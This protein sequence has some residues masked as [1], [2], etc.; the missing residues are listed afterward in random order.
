MKTNFFRTISIINKNKYINSYVGV[1]RHI[2]WVLRKLF[3]IFPCDL[4]LGDQLIRI[5]NR[6]IANGNGALINAMGYYDPNNMLLLKELF[7]KEVYISFFDI[8]ANIGVYSLIVAGQMKLGSVN[9][10]AFEPHPQTFLLLQENVRLNNLDDRISCVQSALGD[11]DGIIAFMDNAGNPENHILSE[12][13]S[14]LE[15]EI[16]RVD[17]FCESVGIYPQ[18]IKIDVEGF[19]NQVL[20]GLRATLSKVHIIFIECWDISETIRILCKQ[21]GFKGPYKN[22]YK[23]RE[24]VFANIHDEDWVFLSPQAETVLCDILKFKISA[25]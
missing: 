4:K 12:R 5:A 11:Y 15:V 17:K 14:G 6:S 2:M 7:Q 23:N 1:F 21:A 18:V 10:F 24:M 20:N 19:E 16:Q 13:D 3:N 22:D 25:D 9:V 8:G